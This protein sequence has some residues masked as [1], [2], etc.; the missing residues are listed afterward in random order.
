[1]QDP[2]DNVGIDINAQ[3]QLA[4]ESNGTIGTNRSFQS[5]IR[6][7]KTWVDRNRDILELNLPNGSYTNIKALQKYWLNSISQNKCN[8]ET[9]K[10]VRQA[11]DQLVVWEGTGFAPMMDHPEIGPTIQ[12]VFDALD[13]KAVTRIKEADADT[14]MICQLTINSCDLH[15]IMNKLSRKEGNSSWKDNDIRLFGACC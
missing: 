2:G 14:M 11:L 4:V 5:R 6:T 8:S 1:M 7:Y 15:L 13:A 9:A 10:Q 12:I 3:W